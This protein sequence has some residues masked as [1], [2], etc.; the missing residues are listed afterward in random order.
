MAF[1]LAKTLAIKDACDMFGK[2]FGADLNRRDTLGAMMDSPKKTPQEKHKE[3]ELL[4]QLDGL[5]ITEDD[6]I[7]ICRILDQKEALRYDMCLK[8]LNKA[9]PKTK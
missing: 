1:P 9:I 7:N 8:I 6:R 4:L 5:I 2:L 3:I